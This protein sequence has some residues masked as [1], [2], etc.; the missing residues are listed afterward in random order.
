MK[1][2]K[3]TGILNYGESF[4]ISSLHT[5][6]EIMLG[7]D[8]ADLIIR[9]FEL[10]HER[11]L[12]K[13]KFEEFVNEAEE[14]QLRLCEV[15]F[16]TKNATSQIYRSDDLIN[17][18]VALA[19]K[20]WD[21][22]TSRKIIKIQYIGNP[23]YDILPYLANRVVHYPQVLDDDI[24]IAKTLLETNDFS[25]RDRSKLK[26]NVLIYGPE[27]RG[28]EAVFNSFK[29]LFEPTITLHKTNK[30]PNFL[31][32][33]T[34]FILLNTTDWKETSPLV[35]NGDTWYIDLLSNARKF[36]PGYISGIDLGDAV[37][38]IFDFIAE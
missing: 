1:A 19:E 8:V 28:K 21:N 36:R 22:D 18:K 13:T 15:D 9:D 16:N 11:L 31:S 27:N 29:L 23:Y 34:Q 32:D 5:K 10:P 2:L 24:Y 38:I 26:T 14:A 6:E 12:P 4:D 30:M 17:I 25:K 3:G 37:Q 35:F 33:E 20:D 7:H